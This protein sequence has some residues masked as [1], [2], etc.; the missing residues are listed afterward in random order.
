M[1]SFPTFTKTWHNTTYSTI[2]PTVPTRP[3]VSAAGN[4][5]F[6]AG[7]GYGI[8]ASIAMSFARASACDIIICGR[9]ATRLQETKA[10][11]KKA[12]SMRV[13]VFTADVTDEGAMTAIFKKVGSTIGRVDMLVAQCWV[14]AR[15]ETS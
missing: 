14:P 12:T 15:A 9:T 13:H 11:V 2:D 6:I 7:G 3:E 5:I 8:G 1:D 10:T 4:N